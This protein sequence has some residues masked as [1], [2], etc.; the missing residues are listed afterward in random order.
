ME[1]RR[2]F[3]HLF[4]A[5]GGAPSMEASNN[6]YDSFMSNSAIYYPANNSNISNPLSD[7]NS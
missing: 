1:Y 3:T 7:N 2:I 4:T 6:S 5:L